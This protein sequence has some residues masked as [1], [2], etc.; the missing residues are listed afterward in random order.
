MQNLHYV[1]STSFNE[2]V[3]SNNNIGSIDLSFASM[4]HYL[5]LLPHLL[6][7]L[8]KDIYNTALKFNKIVYGFN[9]PL[10]LLKQYEWNNN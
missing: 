4:K 7:V 5:L 3:V 1:T 2:N 9:T 6:W 8:Y 10:A